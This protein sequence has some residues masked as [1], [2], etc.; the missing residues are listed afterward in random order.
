MTPTEIVFPANITI[1]RAMRAVRAAGLS[2]RNWTMSAHVVLA[3][4]E[5]GE[6]FLGTIE[7]DL[8][9]G[10]RMCKPWFKKHYPKFQAIYDAWGSV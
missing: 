5:E 2:Y 7:L 8:N 10:V 3:V 9:K 6:H 4:Y 1:E